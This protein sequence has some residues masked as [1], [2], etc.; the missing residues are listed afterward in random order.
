MLYR[1]VRAS[2]ENGRIKVDFAYNSQAWIADV[3]IISRR[4]CG[5]G[6]SPGCIDEDNRWV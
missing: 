4:D 3:A 5:R 1:T 2:V 6:E